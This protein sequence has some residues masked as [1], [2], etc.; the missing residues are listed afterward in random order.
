MLR[1]GDEIE[2]YSVTVCFPAILLALIVIGIYL[3]E[4]SKKL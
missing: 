1:G 4:R 2:F 3:K